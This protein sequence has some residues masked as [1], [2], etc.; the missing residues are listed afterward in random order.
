MCDANASLIL[1]ENNTSLWLGNK[2][3][4]LDIDFLK[5][6]KISLIVNCT[7]HVPFIYDLSDINISLETIRI[8]INDVSSDNDNKILADELKKI[9]PI[10]YKKF[11]YDHKNILIH[12]HAGVSRSASVTA[13]FLYYLLKKDKKI[14]IMIS[15]KDLLWNIV[16]YIRKKR[17]CTFYY[18]TRYNFKNALYKIYDIKE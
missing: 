17:A 9:L 1:K 18:G 7:I 16:K 13:A 14:K 12:C 10:I 15:D 5:K 4:A 3:A 8:P 6:E 11:K 2:N